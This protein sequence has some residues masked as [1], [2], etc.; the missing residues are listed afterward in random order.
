MNPR[1]SM[2]LL[3][4]IAATAVL[5]PGCGGASYGTASSK[6]KGTSSQTASAAGSSAVQISNF[7][8]SPA[9]VTVKQGAGVTVTNHD[10][11]THTLTADDGHSFDTGDLGQGASQTIS[12]SK[13]GSYPFHCTI[14]PFMH[15]KLVVK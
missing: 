14:H 7:K 13:P 2:S 1:H 9:S 11:D 6:P 15:G 12:V 3:A 4:V 10:S 5:L 8:F